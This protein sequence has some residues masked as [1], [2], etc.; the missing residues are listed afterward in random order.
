MSEGVKL[1][2]KWAVLLPPCEQEQG[3]EFI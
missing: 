2:N 3:W 1:N